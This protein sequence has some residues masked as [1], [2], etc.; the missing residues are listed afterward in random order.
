MHVKHGNVV[1][2]GQLI[3]ELY[4]C[5]TKSK[6]SVI[7][8]ARVLRHK[9]QS[10]HFLDLYNSNTYDVITLDPRRLTCLLLNLWLAIGALVKSG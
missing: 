1:E 7:E 2:I 3:F 5:N 8:T 6:E 9:D 4:H 10:S